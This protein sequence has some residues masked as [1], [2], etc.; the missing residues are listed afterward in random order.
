MKNFIESSHQK[1]KLREDGTSTVVDLINSLL[2]LAVEKLK[3]SLKHAANLKFKEQTC[4]IKI[5][6][7]SN[8]IRMINRMLPQRPDSLQRIELITFIK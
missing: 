1:I 7:C 6:N 5:E 4:Y 2:E 3:K 8:I